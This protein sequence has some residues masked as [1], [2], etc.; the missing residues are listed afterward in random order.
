MRSIERA[1]GEA[2]RTIGMAAVAEDEPATAVELIRFVDARMAWVATDATDQA[3]GYL[4]VEEIDGCAHVEQVTVHPAYARRGIGAA[5]I[6]E[7]EDW[8][9]KREL[10]GLTLTTF[11]DVP[12]NAPYY[13]RLGFTLLPERSWGAALRRKVALEVEHGLHAWPRVVM[14]R[15]IRTARSHDAAA[16]RMSLAA[17]AAEGS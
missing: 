8:A 11:A 14:Q 2:F 10:N 6:D 16:D 4:L 9:A 13:S 1:A 3:V 7:A 12:W 15:P 17:E 5:M